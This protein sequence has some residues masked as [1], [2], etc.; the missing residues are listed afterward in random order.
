[1]VLR[2]PTEHENSQ[3]SPKCPEPSF[4]RKQESRFLL[5]HL[6]LWIPA[7]AGMTDLIRAFGIHPEIH[8]LTGTSRLRASKF[9]RT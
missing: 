4:L 7:F 5:R 1:M 3:L 2:A 8:F 9:E 6:S